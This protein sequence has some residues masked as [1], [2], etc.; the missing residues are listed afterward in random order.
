M[1]HLPEIMLGNGTSELDYGTG[2]SSTMEKR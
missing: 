2:K 1:E